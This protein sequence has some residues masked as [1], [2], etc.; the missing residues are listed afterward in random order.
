MEQIYAVSP[1]EPWL[2]VLLMAV[3][4][5]VLLY[6]GRASVHQLI[7]STLRLIVANL[8]LSARSVL[9]ARER[10][11]LRNREVLLALGQAQCQ[12][13]IE[14]EYFRIHKFVERDLGGYP[15]VQRAIEEQITQIDESYQQSTQVPQPSP[16]WLQSVEAIAKLNLDSSGNNVTAK[17]LEEIHI[18]S[19]QQ[20]LDVVASYRETMADRHKILKTMAP[21][22]RRLS[23]SIDS[24]ANHLQELVNRSKAIDDQMSRYQGIINNQDKAVETLKASAFTQFSISLL[25]VLIAGAGAFFNFHLIAYPMSEMVDASNS[26]AGIKLSDISALVLIFLEITMGIFLLEALHITRLFPVIG[27]MDDRMRIRGIWLVGSILLSL[28]AMEAGLAFMRDFLSA[29]DRALQATLTGAVI[30]DDGVGWIT[31]AVNVSMGFILPL[32]LTVVAIP[33]EYLLQTG[34][35]VIGALMVVLL[36]IFVLLLRLVANSVSYSSKILLNIYDLIIVVPLWLESSLH[37]WQ[38]R[39]LEMAKYEFIAHTDGGD[40]AVDDMKTFDSS[41]PPE[42]EGKNGLNIEMSSNK[43]SSKNKQVEV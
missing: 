10:L 34:R 26:I 7:Q 4:A 35:T 13:E 19:K 14:R 43:K 28:A 25:V 1:V 12:R 29:Q 27:S 16:E 2:T 15:Q 38:M 17:I 6:M 32:A 31:L 23:N 36:N 3:V 41:L 20:H 24:V 40:F 21:F 9:L 8:R 33:L 42:C 22:W 18:V 39:R 37:A 5:V 11:Q 30:E